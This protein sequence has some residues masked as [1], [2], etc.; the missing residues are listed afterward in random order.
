MRPQENKFNTQEVFDKYKTVEK[1]DSANIFHLYDTGK[2]CMPDDSGYHDSR[3]FNVW[4]F[5]TNTMEKAF[6]GQH[7]GF[8]TLSEN[9]LLS[10]V[11]VYADGSFFIRLK[12]PAKIGNYQCITLNS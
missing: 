7:D 3:H 12:H 8:Q 10:S 9:I 11:R 6:L 5:N 2:E 1:L 4:A